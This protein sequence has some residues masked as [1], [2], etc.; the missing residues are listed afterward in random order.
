MSTGTAA[1][2]YLAETAQA[3]AE[4]E[5]E[6][7]RA[8]AGAGARWHRKIRRAARRY[9]RATAI[10]GG[11]EMTMTTR[12]ARSLAT[13]AGCAALAA[14]A[15]TSA[16]IPASASAQAPRC[17]TGQIAVTL[18]HPVRQGG[19]EGWTIGLQ[20]KGNAACTVSGYPRLGLEGRHGQR[21]RSITQDGPTY[22]HADPA[23]SSVILQPG[24]FAVA[25]LA[26]GTVSGSG[27]VHAHSLTIRTE[28][29]AS[30]KTVILA[31]RSVTITR[32]VLDVTA[33]APRGKD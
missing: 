5:T 14:A 30:H 28:G 8:T 20:D 6:I 2:A 33:W 26:Y 22:F 21:L 24:G 4:Y 7:T 11:N 19:N 31:S 3:Y 13:T 10:N 17:R 23:P 16:A 27:N 15:L 32:G 25:W 29:A 12:T 1:C 18:E 9:E